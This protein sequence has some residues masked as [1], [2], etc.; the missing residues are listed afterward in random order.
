MR[1]E[2]LFNAPRPGLGFLDLLFQQ[3]GK[4]SSTMQM[5][6]SAAKWRRWVTERDAGSEQSVSCTGREEG[7]GWDGGMVGGGLRHD[8]MPVFRILHE[9]PVSQQR[10]PSEEV[11][12][13]L[14]LG[15][16]F[17]LKIAHL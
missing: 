14:G 12:S 16:H 11:W 8:I 6:F 1:A 15:G 4:G 2:N 7:R 10:P 5:Q 9:T 3:K 13:H 17:P